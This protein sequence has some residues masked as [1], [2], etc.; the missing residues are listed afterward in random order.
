M[1]KVFNRLKMFFLGV[2]VVAT[3]AVWA[4]QYFYVWP[5]KRCEAAG[6]YWAADW[7]ACGTP[8]LVRDLLPDRTLAPAAPTAEEAVAPD[9]PEGTPIVPQRPVPAPQPAPAKAAAPAKA[10]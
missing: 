9:L 10:P 6:N 1:V 4:Y 3:V 8:I 7:R 5:K 2:F